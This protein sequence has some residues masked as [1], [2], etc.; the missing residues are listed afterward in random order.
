MQNLIS[1]RAISEEYIEDLLIRTSKKKS[2]EAARACLRAF[3]RCTPELRVKMIDKE[4]LRAF[5]KARAKDVMASTINGN[6]RFL[7]TVLRYAVNEDLIT[8]LPFKMGIGFFL[9][10]PQ[11]RHRFLDDEQRQALLREAEKDWRLLAVIKTSFYTGCRADELRF[12][13]IRDVDFDNHTI[14]ITIKP[15]YDWAPKNWGE[16]VLPVPEEFTRWLKEEHIPKMRW[17]EPEDFLLPGKPD[18]PGP[19]EVRRWTHQLYYQ[20]RENVFNP[21]GIDPTLKL[22]HLLRAT[23]VTDL[24]QHASVETVRQIVGHS[25]A[26]TTM[27]YASATDAHKREAI[28][29][30]FG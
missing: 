9:K 15:E 22:P 3:L 11:K 27:G 28:G 5:K 12:L 30:M 16:R 24:L 6:L 14:H 4:L 29:K 13:Q 23:Y 7:K 26:V 10:E 8:E 1:F 25:A 20:L 2:H 19:P 18:V 17:A 21:A